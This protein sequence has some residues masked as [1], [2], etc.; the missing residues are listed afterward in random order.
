MSTSHR[1][2]IALVLSV[3]A[4]AVAACGSSSSTAKTST[5]ATPASSSTPTSSNSSQLPKSTP[6][7]SPAF[8]NFALQVA[9][10]SAPQLSASQTKVAAECFQKGFLAAGF[11]TQRDLEK[12]SNGEKE[13]GITVR[14][15]LKAQSHE[16]PNL[17]WGDGTSR[18]PPE[19][20]SPD[21]IVRGWSA[22]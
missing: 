5:A 2:H 9:T 22:A 16:M 13:R 21:G 19:S 4:V 18:P 10:N 7:A 3:A 15:I 14:C 1:C 17:G 12:G 20:G 11:K 6:I 8:Y